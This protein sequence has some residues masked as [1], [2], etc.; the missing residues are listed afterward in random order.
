MRLKTFL[1]EDCLEVVKMPPKLQK[2][3]YLDKGNFPVVA[4]ED[5]QMMKL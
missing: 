2:N 1:F 5:T 3:K 4:Q